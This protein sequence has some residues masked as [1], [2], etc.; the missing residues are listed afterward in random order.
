M[1]LFL[2]VML[3]GSCVFAKNTLTVRF[4]FDGDML[5]KEISQDEGDTGFVSKAGKIICAV[6]YFKD[7]EKFAVSCKGAGLSATSM[8]KCNSIQQMTFY[9]IDGE[10]ETFQ[11][12]AVCEKSTKEKI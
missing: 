5:K 7:S 6:A 4:G 10:K 3:L 11:V 12:G 9:K 1:K 8:I 2:V